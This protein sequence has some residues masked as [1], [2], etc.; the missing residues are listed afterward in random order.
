MSIS[1]Q[2]NLVTRFFAE[3]KLDY[4]I[5]GAFAL[6]AYGYTRATK[7]IDFIT[8]YEY[9]SSIVAYMESLGF[10]TLHRT[11]GFSNHVHAIETARIDFMYVTGKTADKLLS[12]LS[13]RD[14]FSDLKLPVLKP[15]HYL[16]LK[17]FAAQSNPDRKEKD[18][19]DIKQLLRVVKID[20]AEVE[21]QFK[22]YGQEDALYGITE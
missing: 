20:K 18:L 10:E 6:Q 12:S 5:I 11:T 19:L 13:Y 4:A 22:K 9:Q 2:F 16:A 17:L 15:E 1:E 7:D 14:V 21:K 8:R 3:K